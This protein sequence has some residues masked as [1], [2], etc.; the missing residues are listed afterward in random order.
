MACWT[1]I[2]AAWDGEE[3]ALLGSTEWVE[4]HAYELSHNAVAYLNSDT[5]GRGYLGMA[6]S[7]SLQRFINDVARDIEDPETRLSVWKRAQLRAVAD[8]AGATPPPKNWPG[9]SVPTG[10]PRPWTG[11]FPFPPP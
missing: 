10:S 6:G 5:N 4:A 1:I 7:H 9:K 11:H 2:Y 3:P 8:A